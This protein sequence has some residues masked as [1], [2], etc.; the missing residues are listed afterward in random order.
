MRHGR[1]ASSGLTTPSFYHKQGPRRSDAVPADRQ[2]RPRFEL[3]AALSKSSRPKL[4]SPATMFAD[5]HLVLSRLFTYVPFAANPEDPK[6]ESKPLSSRTMTRLECFRPKA[7]RT[8]TEGAHCGQAGSC[9]RE[10]AD[11][12]GTSEH[13]TAR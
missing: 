1:A 7:C 4:L 11:G 13:V 2:P 3:S 9:Q 12:R 5:V 6:G 10:S 8:N